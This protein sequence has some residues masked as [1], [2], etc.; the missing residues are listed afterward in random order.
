[1][2]VKGV[3]QLLGICH[4]NNHS[5]TNG[6]SSP[7]LILFSELKG[8]VQLGSVRLGCCEQWGKVPKNTPSGIKNRCEFGEISGAGELLTALD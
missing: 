5:W 2:M 4:K 7:K 6:S 3:L 8:Q 1:M